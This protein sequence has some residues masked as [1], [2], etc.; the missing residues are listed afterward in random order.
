MI[1]ENLLFD[2]IFHYCKFLVFCYKKFKNTTFNNQKKNI[3]ISELT[4][5]KPSIIG[6]LY[7]LKC[8][9]IKNKCKVFIYYPNIITNRYRYLRAIIG[10]ILNF[11]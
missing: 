1:K 4:Y 5:V 8:L 3:I 7:L 10:S 6:I 11:N 2:K 9:Q